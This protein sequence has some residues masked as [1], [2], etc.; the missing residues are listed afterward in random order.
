[1]TIEDLAI[2]TD[3]V[4]TNGVVTEFP[5][6]FRILETSHVQVYR[7]LIS[8][9][10][11][12]VL[13]E[14]SDY[15]VD[16][17]EGEAGGTVTTTSA[18]ETGYTIQLRRSVPFTQETQLDNDTGWFPKVHEDTF[19][20]IVMQVQELEDTV[21]R[22]VAMS[23]LVDD[24]VDRTLP[25]PEAGKVLAWN[26]AA[27][28]L[29]N[30]DPGSVALATPASGSVGP[31]QF[32]KTAVTGQTAITVPAIDDLAMLSDTSDSGNLKK[33]T[34]ENLWKII[35]SLTGLTAP[36]ATADTLAIYDASAS[37][38]RKIT[39]ENL[40][41]VVNGLTALSAVD[42]AADYVLIYDASAG[43][44]KKVLVNDI[45]AAAS[46][47]QSL[48]LFVVYTANGTFVVP[49][50]VTRIQVEAWGAGG[51]GGIGSGGLGGG[52]GASGGY[53]CAIFACAPADS[54]GIGIGAAGAAGGATG[55]TGGTTSVTGP[56]TKTISCPGGQGGGNTDVRLGGIGGAAPTVGAGATVSFTVAGTD[57]CIATDD[58][59][60]NIGANGGAAPNGGGGGRGRL[61][62]AS[63]RPGVAPGGGGGGGSS[64]NAAT[65]GAGAVG[66]VIIRYQG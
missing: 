24:G 64:G 14:G 56:G 16:F 59:G 50:G 13:V 41:K 28:A 11:E 60:L 63:A 38:T 62:G 39:P 65:A 52:G 18:I 3:P 15:S 49:A 30:V 7:T 27:D 40:L 48:N 4:L 45:L 53:A 66:R 19:D 17:D 1:M 51:G 10:V 54:Y 29:V 26:G 21:D 6:L 32:N 22:A 2:K 35:G 34:L 36:D 44:S 37:A 12:D 8:T 42:G 23:L 33:I 47:Q 58:N 61:S 20:R 46:S 55:T 43:T 5:F 25:T 57:G 31:S 9:G